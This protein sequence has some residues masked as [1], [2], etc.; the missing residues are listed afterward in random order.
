MSGKIWLVACLSLIFSCGYP[1]ASEVWPMFRHDARHTGRATVPGP[2]QPSLKW[3]FKADAAIVSS[4]AIGSD[5]SVYFT[6]EKGT[7]YALAPDG[8][9]R[10]SFRPGGT[11]RSS[12]ALGSDGTVYLSTYVSSGEGALCAVS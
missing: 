12:P 4:P 2:E 6:S 7:L 5:G 8:T 9:L 1:E 10:W 3:K 11:I